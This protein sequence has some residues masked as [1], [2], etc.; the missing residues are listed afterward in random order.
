MLAGGLATRMWPLTERLPKA[1][2]EVAGEPFIAHQ[3]RLF[4]REGISEVKLLVGYCWEQLE[5]FI[6]DGH[7]FGLNVDYIADGPTLLGTGGA[8]RHALG[9]LGGEFL[10]TYGDS[11]LDAPYAPVVEAFDA[12]GQPALMCVFRNENRWDASN[13][14]FENGVIRYYS[15]KFRCQK[16]HHIDW[17]LGVLRANAVA[18]RPME[19]PWDLAELY[20]ELSLSGRLAGYEMTCRFYE[21][22]SFEGLAETDRVVRATRS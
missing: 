6:G 2:L 22:G 15:K 10:V 8:L 4:A 18:T 16:M 13:V 14:H 9:R 21:I 11:W 3:L 17:G 20:E 5:S 19:K 1:L 12:S 7:R